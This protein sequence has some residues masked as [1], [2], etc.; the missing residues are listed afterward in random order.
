MPSAMQYNMI[1]GVTPDNKDDMGH[2]G[3]L[4]QIRWYKISVTLEAWKMRVH[5]KYAQI[6]VNV[7]TKW[8]TLRCF[9]LPHILL[10]FPNVPNLIKV[11]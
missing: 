5:S 8:E 10:M 9:S 2:F 4:S 7:I 6:L 3:I 11:S 1:M